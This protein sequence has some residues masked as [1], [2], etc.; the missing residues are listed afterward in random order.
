M[1]GVKVP[2]DTK[3]LVGEGLGKVSYDDAFAHEKLSPTLGLFRADDFED[4]VAQ[5]VTMVEIGGIGHTSGL[6]TNQDVNADRIRY[7]GDKM[8]TARILVNIPTTHG[9]IGD[10]TTSTLHLL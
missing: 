9:G 3:V 6:Y 4:A 7:F 5:A 1:A 10:F 2:A 8:K